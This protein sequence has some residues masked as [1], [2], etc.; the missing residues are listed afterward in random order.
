MLV[1]YGI[2]TEESPGGVKH[3]GNGPGE[4]SVLREALNTC[5]LTA[6]P[7]CLQPHIARS[8]RRVAAHVVAAQRSRLR[9][10][11][12][13]A[14]GPTPTLKYLEK[15]SIMLTDSLTTLLA[16][17]VASQPTSSQPNA[18]STI[19]AALGSGSTAACW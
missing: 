14:R 8:P 11:Q 13:H 12:P 6:P 17:H 4:W 5:S 10:S 15:H 18:R 7:H 9:S 2:C 16:A 19:H 3:N 1:R